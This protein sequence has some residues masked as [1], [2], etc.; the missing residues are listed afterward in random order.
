VGCIDWFNPS[1]LVDIRMK[2][3]LTLALLLSLPV[4]AF[5]RIRPAWTYEQLHGDA[6]LVVIAKPVSSTHL[7]EKVSLPNISPAVPVVGI[8][9]QFDVRL[10][11][12][13][14]VK[15]K[16][17]EL[18]HYALQRPADGQSRGA[19]QLVSFDPKQPACYLM[20]L[21]READN[22]YAPVTGQT[23]PAAECVIKLEGGAR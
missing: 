22:R 2:T 15:S 18:H 14:E 4:V 19:P 6:D 10:V 23:D 3:L 5:G 21:K 20:F 17:I 7:E 9:T 12:K 1:V 16:T 11:L 8:E 13:G